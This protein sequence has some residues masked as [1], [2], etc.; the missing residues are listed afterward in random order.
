MIGILC[1]RDAEQTQNVWVENPQPRARITPL[2]AGNEELAELESIILIHS[3]KVVFLRRL[4]NE[5][6]QWPT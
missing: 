4:L 5:T 1:L 6:K 3:R 2:Q